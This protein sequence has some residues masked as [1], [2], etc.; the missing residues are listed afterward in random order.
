MTALPV[1]VIIGGRNP[2]EGGFGGTTG[3]ATTDGAAAIFSTGGDVTGAGGLSS[4][5]GS[6]LGSA[7][8]SMRTG[9][10]GAGGGGNVGVASITGAS[11]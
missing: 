4:T 6:T 8:A 11:T 7:L 9:S 5:F 1:G 2:V 10:D 3:G